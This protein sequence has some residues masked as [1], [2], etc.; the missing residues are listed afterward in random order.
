MFKTGRKFWIIIAV[1]IVL[2]AGSVERSLATSLTIPNWDF[3]AIT[4]L[5]GK[6]SS[7][8][9]IP[10][11][12]TD[13]SSG[14]Y[15]TWNPSSAAYHQDYGGVNVAWV[16]YGYFSQVLPYNLTAG[17]LYTLTVDVGYQQASSCSTCTSWN[18]EIELLAGWN[19]LNAYSGTGTAGEWDTASLT[20][21]ASASG[22]PL[23][24]RLGASGKRSHF[25]N[26]RLNNTAVP[27][28]GTL[29]LL[30]SGLL[31]L[32]VFGKKKIQVYRING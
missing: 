24:I 12:N 25:D 15:G 20:Y 29:M 30:G 1:A 10:G 19:L 31:G 21:L 11:W 27:E 17:H 4:L 2:M 9:N 26:V 3:E 5:D 6:S 22:G 32:A 28:P 14:I 7:L 18:Y 23:E 8:G 16:N 13:Q